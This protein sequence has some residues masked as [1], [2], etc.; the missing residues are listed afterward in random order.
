MGHELEV[1]AHDHWQSP[2]LRWL[3]EVQ[4]YISL[5]YY[6]NRLH[7]LIVCHS[8]HDDFMHARTRR[9]LAVRY[10]CVVHKCI[11]VV[12]RVQQQLLLL[13]FQPLKVVEVSADIR[14]NLDEWNV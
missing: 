3:H 1:G 11:L 9:H 14:D 12:L 8:A 7:E 2:L 10:R 6:L 4:M 5:C 13:R